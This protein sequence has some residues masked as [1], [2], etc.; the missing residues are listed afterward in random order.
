[1]DNNFTRSTKTNLIS[2]TATID[3]GYTL[4]CGGARTVPVNNDAGNFLFESFPYSEDT[5]KARAKAH[6]VPEKAT[7]DVF[8]IGVRSNDPN[9]IGLE[10][11]VSRKMTNIASE[12]PSELVSVEPNFTLTGGGAAIYYNAGP[13]NLL[14]ASYPMVDNNVQAWS[15]EGKA[16]VL[17][18]PALLE[19]FAIG[20]FEFIKIR[21]LP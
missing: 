4:T 6:R 2:G 1:M 21:P 8:A 7:I 10:R 12:I 20:V 11:K 9:N 14:T 15:A 17:S 19:V 13:G 5:W 16:H 18:S 3:S